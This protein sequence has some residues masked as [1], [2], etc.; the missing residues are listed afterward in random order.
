MRPFTRGKGPRRLVWKALEFCCLGFLVKIAQGANSLI[1]E[2]H[3]L[4]S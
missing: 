2:R 4:D 1:S 3:W